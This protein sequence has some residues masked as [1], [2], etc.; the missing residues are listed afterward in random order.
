M[1]YFKIILIRSGFI[2]ILWA[3]IINPRNPTLE[4]KKKH[5]KSLANNLVFRSFFKTKRKY[6]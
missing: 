2:Y 5:F 6:F 1:S 3:F 4:R